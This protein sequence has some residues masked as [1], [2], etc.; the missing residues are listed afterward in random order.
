MLLCLVVKILCPC[1]PGS[2]N[3]ETTLQGEAA[4]RDT[5]SAL[6]FVLRL[7]QRKDGIRSTGRRGMIDPYTSG[8]SDWFDCNCL[9]ITMVIDPDGMPYLNLLISQ[10]PVDHLKYPLWG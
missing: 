4:W 6:L 9:L 8:L 7:L 1:C 10:V 5:H 3:F 2:D